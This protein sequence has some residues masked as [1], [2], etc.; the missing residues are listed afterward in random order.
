MVKLIQKIES[1]NPM[2]YRAEPSF[3]LT[4]DHRLVV[5]MATTIVPRGFISWSVGRSSACCLFIISRDI[6]TEIIRLTKKRIYL[7][8]EVPN[9][10]RF[11]DLQ[12]NYSGA[13]FSVFSVAGRDDKPTNGK[14]NENGGAIVNNNFTE[15]VQGLAANG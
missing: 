8:N 5:K 7:A 10:R 15:L 13:S 6:I 14:L 1:I 12:L 9:F 3:V 2:L 4:R 11:D